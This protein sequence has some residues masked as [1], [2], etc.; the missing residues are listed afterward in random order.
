MKELEPKIRR[1]SVYWV[2]GK[3]YGREIN[4]D[5]PFL[6]VSNGRCNKYS[7]HVIGVPI[8]TK[9]KKE[10]PTHVPLWGGQTALCESIVT[11]PREFIKE[12]TGHCTKPQMLEVER[13]L[14]VTLGLD[15][16]KASV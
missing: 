2:C 11:I 5:R 6:I 10:L 4:K 7:P 9:D 14:L 16:E 12:L 1:G 13:A 15:T 3:L 8:T